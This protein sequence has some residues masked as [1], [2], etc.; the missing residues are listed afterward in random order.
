M[1]AATTTVAGARV[2]AGVEAGPGAAEEAGRLREANRH[3][4]RELGVA[5]RLM[6]GYHAQWMTGTGASGP[7]AAVSARVR[8]H[9]P[10]S[11]S[12]SPKPRAGP[13]SRVGVS[14]E[15]SLR[16]DGETKP[17]VNGTRTMPGAGRGGG[18]PGSGWRATESKWRADELARQGLIA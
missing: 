17:R 16:N 9:A 12:P 3:L 1:E 7:A 2:E 18:N 5:Q 4:R 6:T 14:W 10:F 11:T 15:S 8:D 13:R